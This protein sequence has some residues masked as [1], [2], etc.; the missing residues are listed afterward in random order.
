MT[1]G[2]ADGPQVLRHTAATWLIQAGV[3]V[4]EA[5]GYLGTPPG[6]AMREGLKTFMVSSRLPSA[7]ASPEEPRCWRG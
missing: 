4:F 5:S 7:Y 3:S 6:K 1:G 2:A